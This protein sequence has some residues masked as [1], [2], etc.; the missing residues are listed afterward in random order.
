LPGVGGFCD[1]MMRPV[2]NAT[3]GFYGRGHFRIERRL[4]ALR[5]VNVFLRGSAPTKR[6]VENVA[7][8]FP[9]RPTECISFDHY[10]CPHRPIVTSAPTSFCGTGFARAVKPAARVRKFCPRG[11][12]FARWKCRRWSMCL[13]GVVHAART[14]A[15]AKA[16]KP[17][18]TLSE[19]VGAMCGWRAAPG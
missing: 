16:E 15:P 18:S 2:F 19:M 5:V 13:T 17:C 12:G 10:V 9:N 4:A 6:W 8:F 3:I 11:P 7:D 1:I 14:V